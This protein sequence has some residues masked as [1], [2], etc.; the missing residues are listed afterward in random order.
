MGLFHKRFESIA[1]DKVPTDKKSL[2]DNG[3]NS[4]INQTIDGEWDVGEG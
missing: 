2:T 3:I 4:R 1:K